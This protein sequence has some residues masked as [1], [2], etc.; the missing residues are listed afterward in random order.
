[1]PTLYVALNIL[2]P[3]L[4]VINQ[5]AKEEGDALAE[6]SGCV[7]KGKLNMTPGNG[8]VAA[9]L[10]GLMAAIMTKAKGTPK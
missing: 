3:N 2:R 6:A 9:V 7:V 10:T 8:Q 4:W 5:A 1:M